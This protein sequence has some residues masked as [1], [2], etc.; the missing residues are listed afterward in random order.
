MVQTSTY[1]SVILTFLIGV[2]AFEIFFRKFKPNYGFG[3]LILICILVEFAMLSM[4][5]LV[6]SSFMALIYGSV[7][8]GTYVCVFYRYKQKIGGEF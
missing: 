7:L 6:P 8:M 4:V 5:V 2:I 3:K 1:I